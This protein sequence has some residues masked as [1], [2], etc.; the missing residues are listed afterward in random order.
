[1][2]H[3]CTTLSLF[4]NIL[5][6]IRALAEDQVNDEIAVYLAPYTRIL[7]CSGVSN[8]PCTFAQGGDCI[9]GWARVNAI[10]QNLRDNDLEGLSIFHLDASSELHDTVLH[11]YHEIFKTAAAD[12]VSIEHAS[13]IVDE[14]GTL[15]DLKSPG[16]TSAQ[17]VFPEDA[18]QRNKYYTIHI[19]KQGKYL[20][21]TAEKH[22]T[23][24][25]HFLEE[26]IQ[27]V[28]DALKPAFVAVH[29]YH[30]ANED[31]LW[32]LDDPYV[33]VCIFLSRHSENRSFQGKHTA[34][35]CFN[36]F[37][38]SALLFD[39]NIRS[40]RI[41][42]INTVIL[43]DRSMKM[44]AKEIQHEK[45]A[46]NLAIAEEHE[47]K[48]N[49]VMA[50][51]QTS[52]DPSNANTSFCNAMECR[53][54]NFLADAL[55]FFAQSYWS[56]LAIDFSVVD[57]ES[58]L[59][60]WKRGDV[61]RH[62]LMNAYRASGGLFRVS[63]YGADLW[64]CIEESVRLCT[65]PNMPQFARHFLQIS[66]QA[67]YAFQ[68]Y[69]AYPWVRLI[70]FETQGVN[71]TDWV[72]IQREK[73]YHFVAPRNVV[74]SLP[75][76]CILH[77]G[78]VELQVKEAVEQHVYRLKGFLNITLDGRIQEHSN[79]PK[80][81]PSM[82][83][84]R[85]NDC[86]VNTRWNR[87]RRMCEKCAF[88]Y[89]Q[90][91]PGQEEC[92]ERRLQSMM[93]GDAIM[94]IVLSVAMLF[95]LVFFAN[96]W[97]SFLL[98]CLAVKRIRADSRLLT[99]ILHKTA[100]NSPIAQSEYGDY[101][102]IQRTTY[103]ISS[104]LRRQF[105]FSLSGGESSMKVFPEVFTHFDFSVTDHGVPSQSMHTFILWFI[106][107]SPAAEPRAS[108]GNCASRDNIC[109]LKH[110]CELKKKYK[111]RVV[112]FNLDFG[113]L[114]I[115]PKNTVECKDGSD[116][117]ATVQNHLFQVDAMQDLEQSTLV[118]ISCST[119]NSP[120]M[121]FHC[122]T[123]LKLSATVCNVVKIMEKDESSKGICIWDLKNISELPTS[124]ETFL[125]RIGTVTRVVRPIFPTASPFSFEMENIRSKETAALYSFPKCD[126]PPFENSSPYDISHCHRLP[127][128]AFK[129]TNS[130]PINNNVELLYLENTHYE[131]AFY[132]SEKFTA[133]DNENHI[134]TVSKK[135]LGEGKSGEVY[136]GMCPRGNLI[137]VKIMS[138]LRTTNRAQYSS[139]REDF[140]EKLLREILVL[141]KLRHPNIVEYL[142]SFAIHSKLL[143]MMELVSGGSLQQVIDN[144]APLGHEVAKKYLIECLRAISFL[145]TQGVVHGDIKPQ[146]ILVD[147]NG[148]C[149]LTDFGSSAL[150]HETT[151]DGFMSGTPFYMAPEACRGV[152]E[153]ASDIWSFGI[154][155]YYLLT[156]TLPFTKEHQSVTDIHRFIYRMGNDAKFSLHIDD[157]TISETAREFLRLALQKDP[158]KRPTATVLLE[159]GF[160]Q[161]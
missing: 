78:S 29:V 76:E 35:V 117:L 145:H 104:F 53:L 6:V 134:W 90:P 150:I 116:F 153:E 58:I 154:L 119:R 133:T 24:A 142:Q 143:L 110:L 122:E 19:R 83:I 7:P 34:Q 71:Q 131:N 129:N 15:R 38:H 57:G 49:P 141:K 125:L 123:I 18:A 13:L 158:K 32:R 16:T 135:L 72:P 77:L 47:D 159:L 62:L 39:W 75:S 152:V 91:S 41:S 96:I 12:I 36:P 88:G 137:A 160:F 81:A 68:R 161:E 144:F 43:Q 99:G 40:K 60:G 127:A 89:Y 82:A 147:T 9:A 85:R 30:R 45:A 132:S 114:L 28:V 25:K 128:S 52:V 112:K 23:H 27:P 74:D 111:V 146:N 17:L 87:T 37:I 22:Y 59:D 2:G 54:G 140:M 107:V 65:L 120:D 31:P 101:L 21:F 126:D 79:Q 84:A 73:V 10:A 100:E 106:P 86:G 48:A 155:T 51:S 98:A 105:L 109:F 50:F 156:N 14:R 46:I 93:D 66:N 113:L 136:L 139:P 94:A 124:D 63:I 115:D 95:I 4:L 130:P 20:V 151:S 149:K 33:D 55:L 157:A 1:M 26:V 80:L 102:S 108:T 67:R 5:G 148:V 103:K 8:K 69:S 121:K 70:S 64:Y 3:V 97:R 42:P 11:D 61:Y 138:V 56:P 44:F 118:V 92:V